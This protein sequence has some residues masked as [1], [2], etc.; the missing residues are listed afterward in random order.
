MKRIRVELKVEDGGSR[1]GK[2]R[3]K[4]IYCFAVARFGLFT[5]F[6]PIGRI[7]FRGSFLLP[8]KG[9]L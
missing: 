3:D 4:V 9:F 2:V 7:G 8:W 5:P 6:G 1:R